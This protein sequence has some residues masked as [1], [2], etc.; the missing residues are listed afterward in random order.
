MEGE[1]RLTIFSSRDDPH[2]STVQIKTRHSAVV[3]KL[4]LWEVGVQDCDKY[5]AGGKDIE[6]EGGLP[7]LGVA[8][9]C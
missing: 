6:R 2:A 3:I 9:T 1:E 8:L 5:N 4:T 7:F